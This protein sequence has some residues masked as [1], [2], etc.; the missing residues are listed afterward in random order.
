MR[1]KEFDEANNVIGGQGLKGIPVHVNPENGKAT[2]CFE[3]TEEEV[4]RIYATGEIYLRFNLGEMPFFPPITTSCLK[5]KLI[6]NPK[7]QE[8]SE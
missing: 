2:A 3:L 6:R 8:E 4:N 7:K 5:E 1:S